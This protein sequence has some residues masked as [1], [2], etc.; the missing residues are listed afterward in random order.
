MFPK[1]VYEQRRQHLCELMPDSFLLFVGNVDEPFNYAGNAYTFRQDSTFLYLFGIDRQGFAATIDTAT[2][3]VIIYADDLTLDDT[4]WTGAQ[5][6]VS[7]IASLSGVA[8]TKPMNALR[9]DVQRQLKNRKVHFVPAYRASTKK[10]LSYLLDIQV[11]AISNYQSEKLIKSLVEMRS[12]KDA[13]EIAELENYMRVGY[14]M[15]V[16]AMKMAQDGVS[17]QVVR[18]V[19]DYVSARNGGHVSFPTICTVRGETLHNTPSSTILKKG[20]LLL[21][22][23]GSESPL[24]Y[25]TDNTRTSPVGGKF[26]Q[27]QREIYDI[28]LAANNAVAAAARPGVLYRDMHLLAMRTIIDGLKQLGLMKGDTDEA[29]ENGAYALF[30]PHGIGHMLGL[31]VH[32]ME[33]Y[34]EDFVGYDD[35]VKRSTQFGFSALRMA[36]RLQEGFVVTDE[37]GIYFI[38][39]LIDKWKSEGIGKEFIN[40]EKLS[41][42]RNFGGIRLEDDLLI[43]HDGARVLGQR[44]P[45]VADEVERIVANANK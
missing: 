38:P 15:H 6:S 19:I 43:T 36:R 44:I 26:S 11:D 28:V 31:D 2:A 13:D 7:I 41:S 21:V 22:D 5:P 27:Q 25:A 35:E 9:D 42:Y 34:G 12:V 33:S 18:A 24:H 40:F 17:E 29:L 16:S 3:E 14:D 23:A 4:I 20:D 37:P 30:C 1:E 8:H 45:I 32:D 10:I 39:T